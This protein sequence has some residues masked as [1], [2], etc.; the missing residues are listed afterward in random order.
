MHYAFKVH[1]ANFFQWCQNGYS[2]IPSAGQEFLKNL[3]SPNFTLK[4]WGHQVESIK[5]SIY[6]FEILKW[7]DLLI[8]V[9]TGGGK[10]QIIGGMIAYLKIVHQ[11]NQHLI[12]VPNITVRA[13]LVD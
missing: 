5:R 8:N 3:D 6:T 4:L 1:E 10:T 13:R 11:V 2:G 7:P 9:V 12:L